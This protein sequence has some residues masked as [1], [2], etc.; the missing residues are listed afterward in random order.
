M[1]GSLFLT[2]DSGHGAAV[3][4][5]A[6]AVTMSW[7]AAAMLAAVVAGILL[8]RTVLAVRRSAGAG[9]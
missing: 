7:L 1:E 9:G 6:L 2:L 3:S 8:A 4:G 5:R